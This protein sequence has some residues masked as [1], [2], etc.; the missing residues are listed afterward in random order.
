MPDLLQLVEKRFVA[1]LHLLRGPARVPAGSSQDLKNEFPL[2]FAGGGSRRIFERNF[3]AVAAAIDA[4][5]KRAQSS[6]GERFIAER[7]NGSSRVFQFANVS[8]PV[9]LQ[10]EALC[11]RTERRDGP[12]KITGHGR[13][14]PVAPNWHI[15]RPLAA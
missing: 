3:L 12:A 6:H 1:D 5:Q 7:D 2:G 15:F 4:P 13:E 10:A 14:K 9:V 8:P 11:L